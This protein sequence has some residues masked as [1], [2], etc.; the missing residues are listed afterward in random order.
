MVDSRNR[1]TLTLKAS[2]RKKLKRMQDVLGADESEVFFDALN[3]MYREMIRTGEI[4]VSVENDVA[5]KV[6]R[7]IT[8]MMGNID[9][10]LAY[11]DDVTTPKNTDGNSAVSIRVG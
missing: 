9:E 3:H 11:L 10:D 2:H 5:V 8:G 4:S 6:I 7:K 1:L